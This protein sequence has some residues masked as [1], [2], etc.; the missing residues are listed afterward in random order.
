MSDNFFE[1]LDI[2]S[3]HFHLN[4]GAGSQGVQTG[5]MLE[6]I[7]NILKKELPDFLVVY[8][9]TNSTLAGALA[10]VKLHIPVAHVEA[11]LRSFNRKMPEEINRVLCDHIS[12]LLFCPSQTSIKNLRDEGITK[13]VECVGD[14]MYDGMLYYQEKAS[15]T[16]LDFLCIEPNN[17]ILA[18]VHRAENTDNTI[19]LKSI[20]ENLGNIAD[21]YGT[22]VLA[23]HPRT[24][25]VLSEKG[26]QL[27]KQINVIEPTR[28]LETISLLKNAKVIMTD[29]G[30]LQKEA[31]FLETPCLTLRDE[32]EWIETI[33]CG[34]NQLVGVETK[35]TTQ[36][37]EK[38]ISGK[39]N[40]DFSIKP[41]G[42]G[43]AA[44]S[45]I[46][47]LKKHIGLKN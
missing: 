17:Y 1:E 33:E 34:A 46:S 32:T 8:G 6:K 20:I 35:K 28:Y 37:I 25:K 22:V 40:P 4:I 29:S 38:I 15:S 14:I 41:Y 24:R 45:I 23:L 26:I 9:D 12:N 2:P 11:G 5:K 18:T 7:E 30:G 16:I 36:A 47:S 27:S 39:L 44:E 21:Y 42:L 3:P 13:G 10:A 19:R 43:N 31:F